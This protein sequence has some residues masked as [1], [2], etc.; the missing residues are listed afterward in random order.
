MA[1]NVN[2]NEFNAT[3]YMLMNNFKMLKAEQEILKENSDHWFLI[4][5]GIII[6][7]MYYF[8]SRF[9]VISFLLICNIFIVI[10]IVICIKVQLHVQKDKI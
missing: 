2:W 1:A 4:I 3:V 6:S 9:S 10:F 8:I 7:C 5:N